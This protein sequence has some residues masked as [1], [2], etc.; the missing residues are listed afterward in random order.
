MKKYYQTHGGRNLYAF[1][2][3][4]ENMIPIN[5]NNALH[6]SELLENTHVRL[7]IFIHRTFGI[8]NILEDATDYPQSR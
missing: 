3:Q 2:R 4:V 5:A 7:P 6:F 8:S 1:E